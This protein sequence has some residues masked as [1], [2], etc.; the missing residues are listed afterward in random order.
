MT[1]FMQRVAATVIV[2]AMAA[3]GGCAQAARP[4]CSTD[5]P[6]LFDRVSPAVVMISAQSINPY[7]VQGRVSHIIG[8]DSSTIPK[9]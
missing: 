8:L 4:G 9:A 3:L 7:K 5:I 2:L 6:T 1:S